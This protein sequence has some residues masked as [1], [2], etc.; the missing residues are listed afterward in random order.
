MNVGGDDDRN[1]VPKCQLLTLRCTLRIAC[2]LFYRLLGWL[3]SYSAPLLVIEY[4][5]AS[6]MRGCSKKVLLLPQYPDIRFGIA[7]SKWDGAFCFILL[8][9]AIR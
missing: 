7:R 8:R 6:F 5:A 2:L 3:S 4:L 1:V 9:S